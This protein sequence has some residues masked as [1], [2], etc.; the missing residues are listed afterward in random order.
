MEIS[1]FT[2]H[3]HIYEP[4]QFLVKLIVNI[5]TILMHPK[6]NKQ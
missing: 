1:Y 5:Q 4:A 2:Q 6:I 3:I